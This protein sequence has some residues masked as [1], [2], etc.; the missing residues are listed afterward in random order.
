MRHI[1]TVTQGRTGTAALAMFLQQNMSALGAH[2]LLAPVDH[3]KRTPDVGQMRRFNTYGLT[4]EIISFWDM[5]LGEIGTS[6]NQHGVPAYFE[7]SHMNAKCG[8]IE[9]ILHR[10]LKDFTIIFLNRNKVEIA[11][12]M[13]ERGDMQRIE[14]CWLWYLHPQYPK[15]L[16]SI[17]PYVDQTRAAAVN[18]IAWYVD[19]MEARKNHYRAVCDQAGIDRLELD[20]SQDGWPERMQESLGLKSAIAPKKTNMNVP[21]VQRPQFDKMFEDVFQKA[22]RIRSVAPLASHSQVPAAEKLN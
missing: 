22:D 1:F 21:S 18:L 6:L 19:E 3:G 2:E 17:E 15:N 14:N 9:Y 11:R 5:K 13:Y 8:L 16:V 7:T 12:S 10:D 4:D 20:L